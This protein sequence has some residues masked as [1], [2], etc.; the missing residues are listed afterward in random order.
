[1]IITQVSLTEEEM[2]RRDYRDAL[3]IKIDG[4]IALQFHDGEP[5]DNNT[6]RNFNDI[7]SIIHVLKQV[8]AAGAAGESLAVIFE[9]VGE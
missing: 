6:G 8:H 5:E 4:S 7:Y 1:M 2:E 9:E 3:Q